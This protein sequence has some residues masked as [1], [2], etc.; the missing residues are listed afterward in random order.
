MSL[1]GRYMS[2]SGPYMSLSGPYMSL[3]GPYMSLSELASDNWPTIGS[4]RHSFSL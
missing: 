2:L 4:L 1:S 3:S